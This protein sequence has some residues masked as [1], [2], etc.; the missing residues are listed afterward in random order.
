VLNEDFAAGAVRLSVARQALRTPAGVFQDGQDVLEELPPGGGLLRIGGELVCYSDH[1]AGTGTVVIAPGGRALL[2]TI[3][4]HHPAGSYANWV[5]TV[6]ATTLS[7][8]VSAGGDTLP[9]VDTAGFPYEGT[10]L[11][12][13]ELIHY[14]RIRQGALEMPR[15]SREPGAMDR[16]GDG[17]FRGRYGTEP[18]AHLA[19]A[20]VILFP[21]RYWDRQAERA[22][23][24]ELA[25]FGL[26]VDQPGA[27]WRSVFWDADEVEGT[28]VYALQRAVEPG[29]APAPPWDG[30]PEATP[31]LALFES[32]LVASGGNDLGLQADRLEWRVFVRYLDGAFDARDGLSHA[33][34]RS[35]RLELFGVDHLAPNQVLRR[36]ER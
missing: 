19:G 10:V 11:V 29:R 1:D 22:D 31:G 8:A 36:V 17:L 30:D 24:P 12:G 28:Q 23:A 20:P 21:F 3:E 18:A 32:G 2:G 34:K 25:Y 14:T 13:D 26:S 6:A 33:W 9:L 5:E 7:G 35:P 16:R 15:A 27:F 4:E